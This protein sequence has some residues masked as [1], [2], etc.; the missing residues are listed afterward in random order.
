MKINFLG[1]EIP[2]NIWLSI[3][4][5][6]KNIAEQKLKECKSHIESLYGNN[7]EKFIDKEINIKSKVAEIFIANYFG[8]ELVEFGE[9]YLNGRDIKI[10]DKYIQVKS[11]EDH[12]S[13]LYFCD[14]NLH[15][16]F[17]NLYKLR[18]IGSKSIE[19]SVKDEIKKYFE[20]ELLFDYLIHVRINYH[21]DM[22]KFVSLIEK[23]DLFEF[24]DDLNYRVYGFNEY[25]MLPYFSYYNKIKGEQL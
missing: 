4:K 24:L 16:R 12:S 9:D 25:L 13:E 20:D 1:K 22:I 21:L 11:L 23:E 18:N 5:N 8:G 14:A 17:N 15:S 19:N 3:D 7:N 10:N 6:Y 2:L